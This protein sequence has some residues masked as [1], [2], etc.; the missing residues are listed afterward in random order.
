LT[1]LDTIYTQEGFF[2]NSP[3]FLSGSF[4]T[5]GRYIITDIITETQASLTGRLAA[6]IVFRLLL[7][8]TTKVIVKL[9][10]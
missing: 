2:S 3:C 7:I 8:S 5:Q 6:G 1:L 4:L 10:N 9:E